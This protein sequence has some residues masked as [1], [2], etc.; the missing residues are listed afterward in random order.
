MGLSQGLL[1]ALVADSAP[2]DLR[3]TAFG[4]FNLLTGAAL[5]IASVLAGWLWYALGPTAT[6]LAGALFSAFA[7]LTMA[8]RVKYLS[9]GI[10]G[11]LETRDMLDSDG[12]PLSFHWNYDRVE[13]IADGVVHA[14]GV[15]LGL[16]GA[17]FLFLALRDSASIGEVAS[18]A[19]YGMGLLAAL[20]LSAT[21]NLWP[22]S[23]AKWL[24]RRF[25][26]SAI[27]VL[28]A[29]TYTPFLAQ[30][31]SEIAAVSLMIVVW[32]TALIG[33]SMKLLLP[34]RFD[35]LSIALYLL[36]GWSGV[37]AYRPM[38][39]AL[40]S[41]SLWLLLTGGVLYSAGVGF[42]LWQKL[43]FQNAIWHGFVLSAACCHY[44]AVLACMAVVPI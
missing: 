19:V 6:F 40:P 30:L 29:A 37:I 14:T 2:E 4:L 42:H 16:A 15:C 33:A 31:K 13:V 23:S 9:P 5:L 12:R 8:I 35:R 38:V 28:I 18:V 41:S 34:G 39:A 32:V 21:Y 24:L 25:D 1:S 27:Y 3:G 11:T 43:R 20:G 10:R 26:H 7:A 44:T 36:L 22:V 17:I